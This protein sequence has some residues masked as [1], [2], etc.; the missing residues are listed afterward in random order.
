MRKKSAKKAK[1]GPTVLKLPTEPKTADL[2]PAKFTG[3]LHGRE[4]VGKTTFLSQFPDVLFLTTEPGTKGLEIFEMPI[5][6]WS[7]PNREESPY[8]MLQVVKALE[9]EKRFQTV[10]IDTVDLAYNMCLKHVCK[11]LD[12]PYPGEDEVGDPD[13][14]KSWAAVRDEFTDIVARIL[15]TERGLWFISHSKEREIKSRSGE[16]YN[17]IGPSLS[18]QAAGVIE[19]LV[20]IIFY[21]DYMRTTDGH[22]IRVLVCEGDETVV[23]GHRETAGEF[24]PLLPLP[25]RDAYDT[26]VRAFRGEH[27]GLDA[28]LLRGAKTTSPT[29]RAHVQRLARGLGKE[30]KGKKKAKRTPVKKTPRKRRS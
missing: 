16:R 20:D 24:P 3:L 23:A 21:A 6:G 12:I 5:G 26:Y 25:R 27:P 22:T 15:R 30:E 2:D 1:K 10:V 14:G 17:K 29:L 13:Y 8:G 9:T 7:L 19:P 11:R 4:K 28:S 18:G